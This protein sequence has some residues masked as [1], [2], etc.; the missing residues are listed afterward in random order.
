MA[1]YP[2]A[3]VTG[4]TIGLFQY[5]QV[6]GQRFKRKRGTEKWTP[7]QPESQ[8]T[9]S[10]QQPF[11]LSLVLQ[12]Q[13]PGEPKHWSLFVAREN[14]PGMVYQVKG[15][16]QC[17][18]YQ[19]STKPRRIADSDSF[20]NMYELATLTDETAAIVKQVAEQEPPPRAETRRDVKENCQGW[21]VRVLEKLVAHGIMPSSKLQMAEFMVEA[22]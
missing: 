19:P 7:V 2:P 22:V 9:G 13:A 11:V 6:N 1:S 16:A 4:Q 14:E 20:L 3:D 18:S 8:E 5:C 12:R 17:M 15:D 21:T 10:Q